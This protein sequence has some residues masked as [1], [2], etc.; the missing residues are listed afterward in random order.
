MSTL[1][2]SFAPTSTSRDAGTHPKG[3]GH[4]EPQVPG[5]RIR[6][7]RG[8]NIGLR[9]RLTKP[10]YAFRSRLRQPQPQPPPQ[11]PLPLPPN[12]GFAAAPCTAKA[13]ICLSTSVALHDGHVITWSSLRTSSSK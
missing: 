7:Q 13:E 12:D 3:R 8:K 5:F 6:A 2:T 11:Q 9:L 10:R 1:C 4:R